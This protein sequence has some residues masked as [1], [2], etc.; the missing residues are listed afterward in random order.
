MSFTRFSLEFFGIQVSSK[1]FL[2]LWRLKTPRGRF[3][4]PRW[5]TIHNDEDPETN[6]YLNSFIPAPLA[7]LSG[8]PKPR[9]KLG[10]PMQPP[11]H[12]FRKTTMTPPPLAPKQL[13]P[14]RGSVLQHAKKEADGIS[15]T[16]LKIHD[17]DSPL[18]LFE[19]LMLRDSSDAPGASRGFRNAPG[20]FAEAHG[21][22][23]RQRER[24]C[25]NFTNPASVT[26]H[27]GK[28]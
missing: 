28:R 22:H 21:E 10:V 14:L 2:C 15:V 5:T 17:H 16:K 27:I 24:A 12:S 9:P 19:I 1:R 18:F 25:A 23:P 26:N 11:P 7:S 6:N 4:L 20:S 13:V 8:P 3:K